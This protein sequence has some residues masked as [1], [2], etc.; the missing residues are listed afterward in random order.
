MRDVAAE[1]VHKIV[2]QK[3]DAVIIDVLAPESY[4]MHHVPGAVNI[5][6]SDPKFLEKVREEV[7]DKDTP[8]VFYCSGPSCHASPQAARRV[9]EAGYRDVRE[10]RGGLEEWEKSGYTFD[11]PSAGI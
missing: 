9:E 4:A 2:D 11:G 7:P 3:E 10:F 6:G 5:P 8:V 1:E